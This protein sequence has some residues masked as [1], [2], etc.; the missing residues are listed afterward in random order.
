M[1][2]SVAQLM[3]MEL[4]GRRRSTDMLVE[5]IRQ[6][7]YLCLSAS[8]EC[9]LECVAP[10]SLEAIAAGDIFPDRVKNTFE[11]SRPAWLRC[12]S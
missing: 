4:C 11:T 9:I 6:C 12:F 7:S 1:G 3:T 8:Q 2:L 5:S 10:S